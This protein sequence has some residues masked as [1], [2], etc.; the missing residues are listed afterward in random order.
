MAKKKSAY[1]HGDLKAALLELAEREI[2]RQSF[3][4][5]TLQELT[6]AL[7]VQPSAAYR[8]FRNREFLLRSLAKRGFDR[9]DQEIKSL[10]IETP[11]E[12]RAKAIFRF[13]LQYAQDQPQMYR[14]M[15]VSDF[16]RDH[17]SISGMLSFLAF[18][19]ALSEVMPPAE[20]EEVRTALL[21]TWTTLHG[22]SLLLIE[23]RLQRFYLGNMDTPALVDY[24]L[25][26]HFDAILQR[27]RSR[28]D[29]PDRARISKV[30]SA[31]D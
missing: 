11:P 21:A 9:W 10:L 1:H 12:G 16:G 20:E 19:A 27:E 24:L 6:E 4:K 2:E 22:A 5:I 13:F 14:L 17:R 31:C 26:L 29:L 18:E 7:G 25:E 3:E 28:S 23:G 15:F 8:H 30:A